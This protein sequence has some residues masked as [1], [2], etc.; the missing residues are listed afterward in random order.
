[1]TSNILTVS[2]TMLCKKIQRQDI[3]IPIRETDMH[4]RGL[5]IIHI[6]HY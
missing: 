2:N 3:S 6:V 1:M 4:N 5:L